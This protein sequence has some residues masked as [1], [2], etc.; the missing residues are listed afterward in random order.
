MTVLWISWMGQMK[1][2]RLGL[3]PKE[4][5]SSQNI[6]ITLAKEAFKSKTKNQPNLESLQ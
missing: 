5:P 2:P 6:K 1:S 3:S 4:T